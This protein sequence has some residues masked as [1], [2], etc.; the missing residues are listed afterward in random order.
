M[1]GADA[2]GITACDVEDIC[3]GVISNI[4]FGTRN[5]A[6][7]HFHLC[8]LAFPS[9]AFSYRISDKKGLFLWKIGG[10]NAIDVKNAF[11]RCLN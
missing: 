3:L 7:G 6:F 4:Q 9:M 11:G 10:L 8:Y 2:H 1:D 5:H